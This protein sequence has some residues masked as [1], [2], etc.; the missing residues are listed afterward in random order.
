MRKAGSRPLMVQ[1]DQ[2]DQG[3]PN[4]EQRSTRV[5]SKR[6]SSKV[7]NMSRPPRG[8]APTT[9]GPVGLPL[10]PCSSLSRLTVGTRR[11]VL[12]YLCVFLFDKLLF[13]DQ[14]R[15]A[16]VGMPHQLDPR[17]PRSRSAKSISLLLR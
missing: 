11:V 17:G 10:A 14:S 4:S 16:L 2:D 1:H 15:E 6:E 8:A 3:D 7:S 12:A 5:S 9:A 13:Y